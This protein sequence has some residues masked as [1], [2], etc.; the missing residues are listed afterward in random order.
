[1]SETQRQKAVEEKAIKVP[2]VPAHYDF[3]HYAA[4]KGEQRKYY[5][6]GFGNAYYIV[7]RGK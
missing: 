3:S 5:T 6:D 2:I 4:V 7:A 1:M